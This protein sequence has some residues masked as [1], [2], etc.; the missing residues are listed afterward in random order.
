MLPS[1]PQKASVADVA[2]PCLELEEVSAER[3]RLR[4]QLKAMQNMV[5]RQCVLSM[6]QSAAG[7]HL[8]IAAEMGVPHPS[9][10]Q[11]RT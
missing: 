3:D 7:C 11:K 1:S 10:A 4:Q 8:H 9:A 2:K 5:A 6:S